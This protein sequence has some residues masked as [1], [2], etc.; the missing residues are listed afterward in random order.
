M[1]TA[2]RRTLA[3]AVI[4]TIGVIAAVAPPIATPAPSTPVTTTYPAS[5]YRLTRAQEDTFVKAVRENGYICNRVMGSRH[6]LSEPGMTLH[7]ENWT[8]DFHQKAGRWTITPRK[9][10]GQ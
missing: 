7:C 4:A 6:L 9:L 2:T 5:S 1:D 3:F 8:Y 10:W